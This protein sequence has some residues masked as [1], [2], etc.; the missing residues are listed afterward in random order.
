MLQPV[1]ESPPALLN[2]STESPRSSADENVS[3]DAK[4]TP[5]LGIPL[6][7]GRNYHN[8]RMS[9]GAVAG[10]TCAVLLVALIAAAVLI[11]IHKSSKCKLERSKTSYKSLHTIPISA[12]EGSTNP[13]ALHVIKFYIL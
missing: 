4:I 6:V 3:H 7:E 9:P 10:I 13:L 12:P 5:S 8:K 11:Q 2:G 1:F